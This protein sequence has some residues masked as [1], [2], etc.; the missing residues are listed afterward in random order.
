MSAPAN[1]SSS[2]GRALAVL[3]VVLVAVV[4]L[5]AAAV[6]VLVSQRTHAPSERTLTPS[7][8][9]AAGTEHVDGEA[10]LTMRV[11]EGWRVE[12]GDLVLGTTAMVPEVT[13]GAGE[14]G[15]GSLVLVGA[16]TE[17]LFPVEESDN[18]RAAA[19]L[20]TGMGQFFL[21]VPG[22]A[23]EERFQPISS[24]AGEGW[25]VSLRVLPS[26]PGGMVSPEGALVYSA[27]V[28]EGEQRYWL[29]YIGDPADGSM[30]SPGPEWADE[31]ADRFTPTD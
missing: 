8:Q 1:P 25:A 16:L 7:I 23:T 28:G 4:A 31:I 18:Q 15:A 17:D 29:T 26:D 12:D 21:P 27:V 5:I 24:R 19:S 2:S 20:V 14:Q 11:P 13:G 3:L 9:V 10:G 30:T 22:E 6:T